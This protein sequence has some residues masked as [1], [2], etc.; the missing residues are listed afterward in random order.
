MLSPFF[1]EAV[2]NEVNA[3]C[4]LAIQSKFPFLQERENVATENSLSPISKSW[5]AEFLVDDSAGILYGLS[6]FLVTKLNCNKAQGEM[7]TSVAIMSFS[8]CT[9]E[10]T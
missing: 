5:V 9:A 7:D 3:S 6:S 10:Q 4:L 2:D 8:A 1:H